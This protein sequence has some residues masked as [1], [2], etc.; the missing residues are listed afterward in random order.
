M[1]YLLIMTFETLLVSLLVVAL[2]VAV[3]GRGTSL[4]YRLARLGVL[5]VVLALAA[6]YSAIAVSA[7]GELI[8]G[9]KGG[10]MTWFAMVA[11]GNV[12]LFLIGSVTL[13]FRGWRRRRDEASLLP[14]AAAWPLEGLAAIFLACLVL[15]VL[16]YLTLDLAF[17]QS[18]AGLRTEAYTL[19]ESVAPPRVPDEENA[20]LIYQ[21]MFES[22]S[23]PEVWPE[24]FRQAEKALYAESEKPTKDEA[25]TPGPGTTETEQFDFGS[26]ALGEFLRKRAGELAL[27]RQAASLP[28][29]RFERDYYRPKYSMLLPQVSDLRMA[30]RLLAVD[31]RHSL[32]R[33]NTSQAIA[34]INAMFGIAQHAREPFL[35][36]LLVSIAIER[37]ATNELEHLLAHGHLTQEM[38]NQ[39]HV[40]T[41]PTLRDTLVR[42]LRME[43]AMGLLAFC[44]FATG[45]VW[46]DHSLEEIGMSVGPGIGP[47]GV[48]LLSFWL[49]QDVATYRQLMKEMQSIASAHASPLVEKKRRFEKLNQEVLKNRYQAPMTSLVFPALEMVSQAVAKGQ[50][51]RAAAVIGVAAY[52]YALE[53]NRLPD[54][55]ED[56]VPEYLPLIAS[57]PFDGQPMRMKLPKTGELVIYSVGQNLQDDGGQPLHG[58]KGDVT[59]V[60]RWRG[61]N[62]G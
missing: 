37:M 59:F 26:E 50:A 39:I 14:R 56:L 60:V 2:L 45:E 4:G 51:N 35:V 55:L 52:R 15:L 18:F 44:S 33:G 27:L 40:D 22:W 54:K 20:A 19:A 23:P 46:L 42:A 12:L 11:G 61:P 30:A 36:T 5:V 57:D 8:R 3:A 31:A 7:L 21:A 28:V 17:R 34:D 48:S 1:A 16:T 29:C 38:L 6:G 53:H 10:F 49:P 32:T 9:A 24:I 13:I 25:E 43:E 62:G 58:Q 41:T 47:V